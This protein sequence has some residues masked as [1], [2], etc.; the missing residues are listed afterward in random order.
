MS[1]NYIYTSHDEDFYSTDLRVYD[2]DGKHLSTP[3]NED[4]INDIL[5]T[6]DSVYTIGYDGSITALIKLSKDGTGLTEEWRV[7]TNGADTWTFAENRDPIIGA[8]YSNASYIKRFDK[9]DGSEVWYSSFSSD[10]YLQ[11]ITRLESGNIL[12]VLEDQDNDNH[13]IR[14]YDADSGAVENEIPHVS[15]Y[16]PQGVS[17]DGEDNYVVVDR[18]AD[19]RKYDR[20][21]GSVI[22]KTDV[23]TFYSHRLYWDGENYYGSDDS[24]DNIYA[25]SN[26][27]E[28][29]WSNSYSVDVP[30]EPRPSDTGANVLRG[31]TNEIELLDGTDESTVWTTTFSDSLEGISAY[32]QASAF[33]VEWGIKI[34]VSGTVVDGGDPVSGAKITVIDDTSDDIVA[35]T[36]TDTDGNWSA[37]APDTQLH[38]VAQYEDDSGTVYNTESYPYVN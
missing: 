35:T 22:W 3:L 17:R 37:I 21:D 8:Y 5:Q 34:E 7:E 23:D 4:N 32:P 10:Y 26:T 20:E 25:V 29:L 12:V 36:I 19:M 9:T 1:D 38:V 14:E 2:E 18:L 15:E 30:V 28:L 27:G 24:S 6:P 16:H 33:P 11:G 31:E 13:V